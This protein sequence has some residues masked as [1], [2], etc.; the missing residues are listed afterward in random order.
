MAHPNEPI[1]LYPNSRPAT[2]N[3]RTVYLPTNEPKRKLPTVSDRALQN[4]RKEIDEFKTS[5]YFSNDRMF[6][7]KVSDWS[8]R[9]RTLNKAKAKVKA[10]P[11]PKPK[12]AIQGRRWIYG[13]DGLK[14]IL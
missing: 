8:E 12:K 5:Q 9:I 7:Q 4:V 13:K 1:T 14:R 3:G 6:F 2:V 10:S 11:K